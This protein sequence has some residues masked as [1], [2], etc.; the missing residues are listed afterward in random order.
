MP[1]PREEPTVND[2]RE[3]PF[4]GMTPEEVFA[5][6]D[7]IAAHNRAVEAA[8]SAPVV[9][10][11]RRAPID[12]RDFQDRAAKAG[13]KVRFSGIEVEALLAEAAR[14]TAER[15]GLQKAA[16]VLFRERVEARA[17]LEALRTRLRGL[18]QRARST[19]IVAGQFSVEGADGSDVIAAAAEAT[20]NLRFADEVARLL[21]T[22]EEP[23]T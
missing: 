11:V 6:L 2:E 12:L 13:I 3:N 14:L 5:G 7:R 21:T 8:S 17:D 1:A 16:D 9:A 18:E 15:N 19:A 10:E 20:A 4:E 22:P 23:I